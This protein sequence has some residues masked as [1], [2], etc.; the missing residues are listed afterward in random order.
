MKPINLINK[1]GEI[2]P[3][4]DWSIWEC[5]NVIHIWEYYCTELISR[6]VIDKKTGKK[7][8]EKVQVKQKS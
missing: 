2:L 6:F 1:K 8:N 4:I 3:V 7:Y 5:S